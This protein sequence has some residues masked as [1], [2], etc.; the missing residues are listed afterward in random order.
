MIVKPIFKR[1][2]RTLERMSNKDNMGASRHAGVQSG[3]KIDIYFEAVVFLRPVTMWK[4][5][6]V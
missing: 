3:Q 2:A 6:P 5:S 1:R 4:Q